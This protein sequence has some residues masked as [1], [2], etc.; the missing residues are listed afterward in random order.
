M[1]FDLMASIALVG[2]AYLLIAIKMSRYFTKKLYKFK[3]YVLSHKNDKRLF[4]VV[5][6]CL[7]SVVFL[8]KIYSYQPLNTKTFYNATIAEPRDIKNLYDLY[9]E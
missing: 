7:A 9:S 1:K 5:L 3:T 8:N 2:A 4:S 6:I